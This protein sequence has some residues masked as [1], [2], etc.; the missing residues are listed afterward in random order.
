VSESPT[1]KGQRNISHFL[2]LQ[3]TEKKGSN[4]ASKDLLELSLL[5]MGTRG[6]RWQQHMLLQSVT[7]C[8]I[9]LCASPQHTQRGTDT[10][11][12]P[13]EQHCCAARCRGRNTP[14]EPPRLPICMALHCAVLI[15]QHRE[16]TKQPTVRKTMPGHTRRN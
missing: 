13:R 8:S 4:K 9:K 16:T 14:T 15:H 6:H 11:V 1:L 3:I 10:Q 7:T 12:P 5:E 2:S